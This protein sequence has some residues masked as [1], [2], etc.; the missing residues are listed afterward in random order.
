[1]IAQPALEPVTD[2]R[3]LQWRMRGGVGTT[4]VAAIYLAFLVA[5]P[6]LI[7][8]AVVPDHAIIASAQVVADPVAGP[9]CAT[10]P[11]SGRGCEAPA[12][13]K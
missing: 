9:R 2:L 1:M 13:G 10:A 7:R 3:P 5:S 11:E 6:L 8:Y 12:R 4:L